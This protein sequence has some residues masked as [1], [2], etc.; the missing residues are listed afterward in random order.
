MVVPEGAFD[1]LAVETPIQK[2][3]TRAIPHQCQIRRHIMSSAVVEPKPSDSKA[4]AG[5]NIQ[6]VVR[7]RCVAESVFV[8]WRGV[9]W[10]ATFSD[11]CCA[12]PRSTSARLDTYL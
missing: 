2:A 4:D 5:V 12:V 11:T 9:Q 10:H 1:V 6:V 7:C 3:F 8:L